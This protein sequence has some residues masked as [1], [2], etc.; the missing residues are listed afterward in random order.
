MT[1]FLEAVEGMIS[2]IIALPTFVTGHY[3]GYLF[4]ILSSALTSGW[5]KGWRDCP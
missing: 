4:G 3:V 1:Q 5:D 2:V